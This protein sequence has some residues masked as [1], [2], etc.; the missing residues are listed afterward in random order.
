ME[1]S[2]IQH[3]DR[4]VDVHV[5]RQRCVPFIRK[6]QRRSKYAKSNSLTELWIY[7]LQGE[8]RSWNTGST[9]RA[10]VQETIDVPQV[11]HIDWIVDPIDT[12]ASMWKENDK[13]RCSRKS[14]D[15]CHY[16]GKLCFRD[17]FGSIGVLVSVKRVFAVVMSFDCSV[18]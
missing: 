3:F 18:L 15:R 2:Q 10:K 12:W 17:A 13:C 6:V 1:V 9:S 7:Q 11:K 8:G 16:R 4:V 5:R 14:K